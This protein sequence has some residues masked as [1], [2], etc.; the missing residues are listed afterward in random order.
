MEPT[1]TTRAFCSACGTRLDTGARFCHQCGAPVTGGARS[2]ASARTGAPRVITWGVPALALVVLVVVVLV[3][4]GSRGGS[5][6]AANAA[7]GT[8]LGMSRAPDISALT[9]EERADRLFNRVMRLVSEGHVDS[10]AFFAPMALGAF[11]ALAPLN[12]HRRYDIGLI[13]LVTSDVAL[14]KGQADTILAERPTHLLGLTLAA[15]VAEVQGDTAAVAAFRRRLVA[16]EPAERRS[17]LAEYT[18]HDADIRAAL[19]LAR[20]R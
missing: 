6:P 16:A 13:A 17:G 10:A 12:A 8:P 11:E 2:A 1:E 19:E 20:R 14:A 3:Q 5:G 4:S 9:P 18:D 7:G 15:R